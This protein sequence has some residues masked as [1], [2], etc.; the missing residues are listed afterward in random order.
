MSNQLSIQGLQCERGEHILFSD[1]SFTVKSGKVCFVKGSN[2]SGKTTLL[3]T[4]AGYTQPY[5]GKIN[6][7]DQAATLANPSYTQSCRYVGHQNGLKQGLS[8]R[9]NLEFFQQLYALEKTTDNFTSVLKKLDIE[10]KSQLPVRNLSQ[11]QQR[12]VA[13]ARL[14]L[15]SSDLWI[16]DEPFTSLDQTSR[17]I[18]ED[19]MQQHLDQQGAILLVTHEPL[20]KISSEQINVIELG[21]E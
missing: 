17:A 13:L 21:H 18:I 6:W 3:R 8:A 16:L 19:L 9:E 12:K 1:L 10:N 11:G 4:I 14:L 15:G 20:M 2:G 7:N 5:A